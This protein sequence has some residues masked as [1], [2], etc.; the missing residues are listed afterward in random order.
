MICPS[1]GHDNIE[2]TDRCDECMTPLTKVEGVPEAGAARGLARSV[3][4]DNL[5]LLEQ[6]QTVTVSPETPAL[7]VVR[8]MRDARSGCA[9]VLDGPKLAGIFTEHD[10][11]NKLTGENAL[12]TT[13]AVKE[14][15][16]PNPETLRESD[17]VAE[18]LNRMSMGRY[19]HIPILKSDGAYAVTSIKNVLKYIAKEEW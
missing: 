5:S 12:P 2:G 13:T 1:C 11:L 8:L 4:E 17:S 15:M 6:E 16:S 7:D 19:R 18:A 9:L 14:L 10:V 3:M